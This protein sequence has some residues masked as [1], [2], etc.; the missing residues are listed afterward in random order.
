MLAALAHRGPDAR[1]S[2]EQVIADRVVFLG[3]SRLS[4]IDLSAAGNQPMFAAE[5][6]IALVFNGEIYNF[7][8][9][10]DRHLKDVDL[11]SRTD[12]E[13]VLRLYEKLGLRCLSELNGDFAIAIL[14]RRV[15]KLFL[16]RDRA[17]VK[18]LYYTN[19]DG[20]LLFGSEIKALLAGGMPA[21]LDAE[22]LQRYFVFKYT[23]G[24]DTLFRG[25]RRLPAGHYLEYD[26]ASGSERLHRFWNIDFQSR[27]TLSYGAAKEQLRDLLEDA[28]RLRLIA[29]V[30]VGTF[31]SGG[32][33][34]SIIAGLLKGDDRLT[35]Y[36]ASQAVAATRAEGTTSDWQYARRLANDWG[37]NLKPVDIGSGNLTSEQIRT[38][39][40]FADDLI[41]DAAQIPSY[42]ITRGAAGTSKVF[43]S[44]MGADEIFLGYAGHQLALLWSYFETLPR[45]ATL[46]QS[47]SGIDQG[48]GSFKAFRRY[49]YRLGKYGGYPAYRY[50]IF[51]IVGDFENSAGVV[52]GDRAAV[53][54][55]LAGYFPEGED[56]FECYKRFEY[57]NFLQKN[58]S[59]VDRMSM[60]NSVEVRVP[61][62]DH[63]IM[64][65]AYSL[66]R[67]YKLGPLGKAKR[68]LVD[69]FADRVPAY[70]RT[71]R[72]AGFG[73]PIRSLFGSR[74]AVYQLLDLDYIAGVAPFD[75]VHIRRLIDSHA[76]GREDNSSI[77]YALISFQEWY[78]E[79]FH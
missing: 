77:I 50:G 28:T 14:D 34:S 70:V 48:K 38:T 69:A 11:K 55:F 17:G 43:L 45:P 8:A 7:Q 61:Y 39:V 18:P 56:P 5:G 33:D 9:L 44:G 71:R 1:G 25:V 31:L 51:S 58:L 59:Y 75:Q 3:H 13:V 65:F 29:D 54:D 60:A 47:L 41:A 68:V 72:K 16:V 23:P 62:L 26:I 21:R 37:L 12:T 24:L 52:N 42:L 76:G 30:P 64:E 67:E 10:R 15:G 74:E 6:Q 32:L 19:S 53:A 57:D 20:R 40:H 79:F 2:Y 35:H 27:S 4:I 78:R 36:C 63:R 73:M 22:G 49:L 46:L 66:P